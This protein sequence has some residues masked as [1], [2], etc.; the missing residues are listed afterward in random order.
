MAAGI[1]L[2][3]SLSSA[4]VKDLID[5]SVARCKFDQPMISV[6]ENKGVCCG[7]GQTRKVKKMSEGNCPR[8]RFHEENKHRFYQNGHGGNLGG[9]LRKDGN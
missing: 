2:W 7:F 6:N 1:D 8:C 4:T 3:D 5:N 9:R